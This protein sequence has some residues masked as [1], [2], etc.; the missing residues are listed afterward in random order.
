MI[1]S[2]GIAGGSL[3]MVEEFA[4]DVW[5]GVEAGA[6]CC[7]AENTPADKIS[8]KTVVRK[9]LELIRAKRM[10]ANLLTRMASYYWSCAIVLEVACLYR[11][12]SGSP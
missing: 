8:S 4:P 6:A 11:L 3:L 1:C 9:S 5:A 10:E 2:T 7:C 12:K